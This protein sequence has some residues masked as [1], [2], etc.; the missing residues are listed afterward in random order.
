MHEMHELIKG[1]KPV[2][3]I[4]ELIDEEHVY[5]SNKFIAN[6]ITNA[7]VVLTSEDLLRIMN[8]SKV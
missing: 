5:D 1:F 2:S 6:I 8:A 7:D 3:D 4:K